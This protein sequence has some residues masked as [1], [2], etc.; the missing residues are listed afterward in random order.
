MSAKSEEAGGA[1][2]EVADGLGLAPAPAS[3]SASSAVRA[4]RREVRPRVLGDVTAAAAT[5]R[6]WEEIG[7]VESCGLRVRF[8]V[9]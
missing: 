8:G 9:L 5:H 1:A 6:A 3:A 2:G 7:S 4:H